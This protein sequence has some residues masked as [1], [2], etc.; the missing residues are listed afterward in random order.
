MSQTLNEFDTAPAAIAG[1][2]LAVTAKLKN[3]FFW[4]LRTG[5]HPGTKVFFSLEMNIFSRVCFSPR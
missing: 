2:L 4:V 5:G 1:D 3:L